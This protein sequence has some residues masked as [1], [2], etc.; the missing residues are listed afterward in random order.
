MSAFTPLLDVQNVGY[1][2]QGVELL[3]P[4]SFQLNAGEQLCL[5][6][7][8]GSGKSTLLKI[9]ASLLEPTSGALRFQGDAVAR[10]R[11]ERYR[12]QVSYCFQTPT[13][14]GE[15]VRDN[16]AF[17]WRIREKKADA[18][19]MRRWL[20]RVRLPGEILDKPVG[21]LSGG[22]KQRIALLRNLQFPPTVLL[23]DEVTSALDEENKR[24][25][26][27][28]IK[29]TASEQGTAIIWITHDTAEIS[30]ASRLLT[31]EKPLR[32]EDESA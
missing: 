5:T 7:P 23:L 27:D 25:I 13:L 12:R 20:E 18:T 29:E 11:P 3:T 24:V 10:L 9:I 21:Q 28:L 8:S 2:Q 15:T 22:E 19:L 30:R 1:S 6:G 4:V 16:L 32:R 31:L 26:A 14:F 17:P